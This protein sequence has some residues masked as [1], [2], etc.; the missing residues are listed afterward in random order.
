DAPAHAS[1][2]DGDSTFEIQAGGGARV[3]V[4][5]PQSQQRV[6]HVNPPVA[7]GQQVSSDVKLAQLATG[8][9]GGPGFADA[10]LFVEAIRESGDHTLRHVGLRV[11]QQA[12]VRP[13][14]GNSKLIERFQAAQVSACYPG[15]DIGRALSYTETTAETRQR[16]T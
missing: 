2:P 10:E 15:G 7:I 13:Y 6:L 8:K 11:F 5:D 14:D 1:S 12:E 3:L 9:L 16:S 4:L